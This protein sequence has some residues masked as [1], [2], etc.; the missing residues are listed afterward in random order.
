V[1]LD[2]DAGCNEHTEYLTK[3]AVKGIGDVTTE[4]QALRTVNP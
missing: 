4:G 2:K 1:Q 3:E